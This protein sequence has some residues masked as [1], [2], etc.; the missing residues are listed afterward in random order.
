[1]LQS[2]NQVGFSGC[3]AFPASNSDHVVLHDHESG[4]SST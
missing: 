1:M 3:L 2:W 4:H